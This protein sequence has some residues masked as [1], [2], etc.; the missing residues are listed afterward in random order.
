[1]SSIFVFLRYRC[2]SEKIDEVG[3][4]I[5]SV[6]L[7]SASLKKMLLKVCKRS[8]LSTVFVKEYICRMME[9]LQAVGSV[10]DKYKVLKH[11]LAE[12]KLVNIG[13]PMEANLKNVCSSW[14]F[15][16]EHQKH[17]LPGKQNFQSRPI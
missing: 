15:K 16:I 13:A 9:K 1:M 5:V 12:Q 2:I 4:P 6:I 14:Q 17:R 10:L 11:V 8:P 7:Q 3:A